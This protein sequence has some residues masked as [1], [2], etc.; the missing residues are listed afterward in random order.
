MSK[1]KFPNTTRRRLSSVVIINS[2]NKNKVDN[3]IKTQ[4]SI[5]KE[6]VKLKESS[7]KLSTVT[8]NNNSRDIELKISR[9]N[10]LM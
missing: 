6:L 7:N 4:K 5:D 1:A 9:T 8:S 2:S 10:N 3:N